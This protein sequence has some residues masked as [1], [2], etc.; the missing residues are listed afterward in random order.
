MAY[1]IVKQI[2]TFFSKA[3]AKRKTNQ[4][5]D[6][7]VVL[8]GQF[9]GFGELQGQKTRNAVRAHGHAVERAGLLHGFAIVCNGDYLSS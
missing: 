3:G 5:R 6:G 4:D 8:L 1:A 2:F 7:R 9:F